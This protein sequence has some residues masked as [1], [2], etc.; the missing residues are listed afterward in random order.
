M[1]RWILLLTVISYSLY[2]TL[3]VYNDHL[4]V[5]CKLL[6]EKS[7]KKMHTANTI[8]DTMDR[9]LSIVKSVCKTFEREPKQNFC[10]YQSNVPKFNQEFGESFIKDPNTGTIYCFVHKVRWHLSQRMNYMLCIWELEQVASST[11]MALY[12]QFE[13]DHG[14][15][16][17]I[18][19]SQQYFKVVKK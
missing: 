15:K 17:E 14:I 12:T 16:Q 3:R 6:R 2:F 7:L 4:N 18:L 8:S 5:Q 1:K 11:W 9:R 10:E 13:G 19:R